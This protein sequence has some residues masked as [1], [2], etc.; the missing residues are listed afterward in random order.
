MFPSQ[1]CQEVVAET[2]GVGWLELVDTDFNDLGYIQ[3][4]ELN[5]QSNHLYNPGVSLEES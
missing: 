1:D 3:H 5:V 2:V 4:Q